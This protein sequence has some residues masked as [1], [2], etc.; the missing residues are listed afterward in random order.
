THLE[1]GKEYTV[2]GILME[3]DEEGNETTLL[4]NNGN[5]ITAETSFTAAKPD[6]SVEV[7]FEVEGY[8]V[9]NRKTVVFETLY[10][11]E[12][13]IAIHADINDENQTV[14]IPGLNFW[15]T[16]VKVDAADETKLLKNC[17]I[18]IFNADGTVAK[19][20]NGEDAIGITDGQGNIIFELFY[21]EEGYY[22]Q[23]TQAPQGYRMNEDKFP[24]ELAEDYDY[25]EE[26]PIIIRVNDEAVPDVHTGDESGLKGYITLFACSGIALAAMYTYMKRKHFTKS[27]Q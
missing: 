19:D 6:G 4:D 8:K 3:V 24:V 26:N 15:V 5:E 7:T 12:K 21:S 13:K 17:E 22:A 10:E 14:I 1:T 11:E 23:E 20:V 27:V 18:T 2:K 25:A 9:A 16:V